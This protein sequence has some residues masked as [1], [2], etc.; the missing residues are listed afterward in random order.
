MK[1][2]LKSISLPMAT[3]CFGAL[4]VLFQVNAVHAQGIPLASGGLVAG[5]GEPSPVG[6]S[7]LA[8][9][10]IPFASASFTGVLTSTVIVHYHWS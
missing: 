1:A 10:N 9:I 6:G 3:C 5:P 4:A 2:K 7:T 8:S